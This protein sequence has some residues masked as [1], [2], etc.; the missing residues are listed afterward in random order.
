MTAYND[1]ENVKEKLGDIKRMYA[2]TDIDNPMHRT[3]RRQIALG[4]AVN[5]GYAMVNGGASEEELIRFFR[6][7][8]AII[9]RSGLKLD[10]KKAEMENNISELRVKYNSGF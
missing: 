6:Y 1:I 8:F 5:L 7:W 4:K 10:Y 2:T 3:Y 9:S